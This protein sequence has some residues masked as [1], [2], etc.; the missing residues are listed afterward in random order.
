VITLRKVLGIAACLALGAAVLPAEAGGPPRKQRIRVRMKAP[1]RGSGV[2]GACRLVLEDNGDRLPREDVYLTVRGPEP[3]GGQAYRGVLIDRDG[4]ELDMG[5]VPADNR[6]AT[7]FDAVC[8][9]PDGFSLP[10]FTGGS[11][12]VRLADEVLLSGR[13]P[14]FARRHRRRVSRN[15]LR[16]RKVL[17]PVD[18]DCGDG[19]LGQISVRHTRT[20]GGGS[21]ERIRVRITSMTGDFVVVA[22]D[23]DTEFELGAITTG[24][25]ADKGWLNVDTKRGDVI[26]NGGVRELDGF[27]VEVRDA[28]GAPVLAGKFPDVDL[29][30]D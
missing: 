14:R 8:K 18:Q 20:R 19:P 11:V 15:G 6:A 10:R 17:R 16:D 7:R 22:T 12:E 13:L 25:G 30:D 5:D 4:V 28:L 27:R 21:R 26:P 3:A 1:G 29:S 9:L 2:R 23:G 24:A